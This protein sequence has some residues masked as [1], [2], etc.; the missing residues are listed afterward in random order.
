[1]VKTANIVGAGIG[2]LTAAIALAQRGISVRVFEQAAEMV[3]VGAGLQLSPN[4]M[5]VFCTLGLD[6]ALHAVSFAPEHAVTK[7]GSTG[8]AYVKIP[9]KDG[10]K[11]AYGGSYLHVHR[12]DLHR[13]LQKEAARLGVASHLNTPVHSYDE[14]GFLGLS[15]ADINVAADGIRSSHALQMNIT[16]SPKFTG[17]VAWRGAVPADHLPRNLISPDAT[18]WTGAGKHLV[19]YFVRGGAL[20]NFVAVEERNNWTD[21]NWT[22]P[23]DVEVLRASFEGWH[24]TV[25]TLLDVAREVN[26]WALYDKP[27]LD[28][29]SD[30]SVALLGDSCHPTLPFVAQGAAMAIEDAYVLAVC[31]DGVD[32]VPQ[33]LERY[34]MLRKPR[35]AML[36]TRARRNADMFHYRGP[37]GGL[38]SRAKL[39]IARM[40]PTKLVMKPFNSIYSYNATEVIN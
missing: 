35:T 9:L 28:R 34:E 33:A 3:E 19:T 7:D 13:I 30:G 17:Q 32:D 26:I 31:L 40:L 25:T 18:V 36:Q 2:G 37:A 12:T 39:H 15:R 6:E 27:V 23:G 11:E 24:P 4:A 22:Q 14:N 21:P 8:R 1:M 38:V 16:Q 20:V 5:K 29:W 10:A